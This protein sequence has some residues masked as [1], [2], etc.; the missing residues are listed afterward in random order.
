MPLSSEDSASRC[1]HL[2]VDEKGR[3]KKVAD[4]LSESKDNGFS[5]PLVSNF[6]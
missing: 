2:P 1:N 5:D 6:E 4:V 3:V